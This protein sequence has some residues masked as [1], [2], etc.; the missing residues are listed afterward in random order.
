MAIG[1]RELRNRAT[2]ILRGL[3]QRG[4]AV[5]ITRRGRPAALIL[6]MGTPE[7]EDYILAHASGFVESLREAEAD[8][9]R[10]T[11]VSLKTYRRKRGL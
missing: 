3:E 8:L 9:R 6:P 11:T 4:T 2:E 1:I 10:G 5:V 7:A